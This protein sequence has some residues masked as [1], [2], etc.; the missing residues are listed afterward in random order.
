M[1]G[2]SYVKQRFSQ[3]SV[4][5]DKTNVRFSSRCVTDTNTMVF[6]HVACK[7]ESDANLISWIL[8][9][10][11]QVSEDSSQE[12]QVWSDHSQMQSAM[13]GFVRRPGTGRRKATQPNR[14]AF[15]DGERLW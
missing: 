2:A 5:F 4:L 15:D 14:S 7:A 13:H 11:V 6:L 12:M 9:V 10:D 3:L 8:S 1:N